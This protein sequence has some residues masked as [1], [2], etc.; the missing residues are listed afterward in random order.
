[1]EEKL[2]YKERAKTECI[3]VLFEPENKTTKQIYVEQRKEG[4]FNI[5]YHYILL[6]DG[7]LEDGIPFYAYADYRL[8]HMKD[9]VYVLAVGC[10][11]SD[12]LTS[13]QIKALEK[14]TNKLNV[15]IKYE[16]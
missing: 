12:A 9:S 16:E 4:L 8:A 7:D 2:K 5:G 10:S 11:N 13:S 1:M 15:Q 3:R 6:P 14:L